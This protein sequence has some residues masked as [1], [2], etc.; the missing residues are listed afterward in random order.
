MRPTTNP[1]TI[2]ITV[3][4]LAAALLAG[5]PAGA[6]TSEPTKTGKGTVT[7]TV[8]FR[9]KPV[10]NLWVSVVGKKREFPART[11]S[12]G[13]FSVKVPPGKYHASAFTYRFSAF[14]TF[15]GDVVRSAE[16]KRVKV[17]AGRT[18]RLDLD[19]VPSATVKGKV[20][21][22]KGRPAKGVEVWAVNTKRA[23][24]H[25]EIR[26]DSRGRFEAIHLARGKVQVFAQRGEGRFAARG[27]ATVRAV[28]GKTVKTGKIRLSKPAWSRLTVDVQG[29]A[30]VD[31]YVWVRAY[32]LDDG[33]W[34]TVS[35]KDRDQ[36]RR[37]VRLPVG[38]W[39]VIVSGTH[40]MTEPV[41]TVAGQTVHAGEV[42]V[43]TERTD[44]SGR[45]FRP[46]GKPV[47]K[48]SVWLYDVH[49]GTVGSAR[50]D[51][52]G[53]FTVTDV[54]DG[55]FVVEATQRNR[56][57]PKTRVPIQVDTSAPA[58]VDVT[59]E[60]GHT[61]KGRVLFRGKGQRWIT[62][63]IP[64]VQPDATNKK[65]KFVLRAVPKGKHVIWAKDGAA[66]G[67]KYQ[68]KVVRVD[69]KVTGLRFKLKK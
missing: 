50:T 44:V 23:G 53:R 17:R 63:S 26:T 22:A 10:R 5:P 25:H 64:G 28:E 55:E 18:A 47:K 7:G 9:G 69:G 41:R 29:V 66:G 49:D 6:A 43:P 56:K 13:R 39:Q 15:S 32:N 24:E 48:G 16:A 8:T 12:R 14:R 65:G 59:L 2:A 68:K 67:F 52:Q 42:V 21:N 35:A 3:L 20:V 60:Q 34:W 33:D 1:T 37:S 62:V 31:G 51:S 57:F 38:R 27:S 61:V 40:A 30:E 36:I 11:D 45:V 46:D 54:P 19:M 4:A 58:T